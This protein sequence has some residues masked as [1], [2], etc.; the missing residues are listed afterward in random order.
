MACAG[1]AGRT[2]AATTKNS[3]GYRL[4][5]LGLGPWAD[6]GTATIH[7]QGEVGLRRPILPSVPASRREMF[8]RWR[9]RIK[10]TI[11]AAKTPK[12][13]QPRKGRLK[14]AKSGRNVK[15]AMMLPSETYRL[16]NVMTIQT[17]KA[18]SPA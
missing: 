11:A 2:G 5:Q 4:G 18:I 7:S 9:R 8:A 1:D 16:V 17:A 15:A 3:D 6:D 13:Q 10:A 14:A 12:G